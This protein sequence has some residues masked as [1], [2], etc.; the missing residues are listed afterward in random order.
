MIRGRAQGDNSIRQRT[1]PA[2][3][4]L[5]CEIQ[6]LSSLLLFDTLDEPVCVLPL[7]G[8][9]RVPRNIECCGESGEVLLHRHGLSK[10]ALLD[11]LAFSPF[12]PLAFPGPRVSRCRCC[13]YQWQHSTRARQKC[14]HHPSPPALTP[15]IRNPELKLLHQ[16]S[17]IVTPIKNITNDDYVMSVLTENNDTPRLI[18]REYG[19]DPEDV[20]ALNIARFDNKLSMSSKFNEVANANAAPYPSLALPPINP[21]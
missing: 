4:S 17:G 9:R 21:P 12:S 5:P 10:K 7:S 1:R 11:T 6:T 3:D 15:R 18:A 16:E 13:H 2:H 19:V 14:A 8:L 20:I